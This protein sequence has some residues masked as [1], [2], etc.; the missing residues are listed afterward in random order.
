MDLVEWKVGDL[1]RPWNLDLIALRANR[2]NHHDIVFVFHI[3]HSG[4]LVLIDEEVHQNR[5][6]RFRLWSQFDRACIGLV[7]M[8]QA[9]LECWSI[10]WKVL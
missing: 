3:F 7:L 10:R 4:M 8:R 6:A 5:V 9:A 1:V 2:V